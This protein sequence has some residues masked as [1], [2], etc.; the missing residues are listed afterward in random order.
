MLG[1]LS[2]SLEAACQWVL[3]AFVDWVSLLAWSSPHQWMG[4]MW[5]WNGICLCKVLSSAVCIFVAPVTEFHHDLF[6]LCH[7]LQLIYHL[8]CEIHSTLPITKKKYAEILLHYRWLF[9]KGDIIISEWGIFG[10]EISFVIAD[11]SLKA[12]SL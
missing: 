9:V 10:V 2:L 11:I 1:A 12:T 4:L 7:N 6:H 5:T 8:Q 3:S